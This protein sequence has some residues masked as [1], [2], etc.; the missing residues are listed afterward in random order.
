MADYSGVYQ[1]WTSVIDKTVVG[2]ED[3]PESSPRS[4]TLSQ[5]Y[6]NPFNPSTKIK[7]TL[8]KR[9]FVTLK[10]YDILGREMK[11]LVSAEQ[12]SGEY[13]VNYRPDNL[14]SGIYFYTLKAGSF[15]I[16][17]KLLLLR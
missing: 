7:Y 10:I 15:Q 6:P 9:S 13:E 17:K 14:S 8:G 11:T 4:F 3:H 12:A 5:N 2:T 1:V 16:T